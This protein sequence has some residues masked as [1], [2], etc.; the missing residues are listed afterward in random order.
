MPAM[1]RTGDVQL[2]DGGQIHVR[3]IELSDAPGIVELHARMSDRTRYLRFFSSYPRISPAD[4]RRFVTVD[5]HD[6]EALVATADAVLIAVGRYERLGDDGVDAEIAFVVDDVHQGRGIA[7]V[8]LSRLAF[9]AHEA[10]VVRF[11][12][13]VLPG[14]TPMLKVFG[15]AGFVVEQKYSDGIV[16]VAFPIS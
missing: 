12:A 13:D 10:G 16:Q 3:P 5:H 2:P 14:N 8:L 4:L 9:A 11:V 15:S 7:P 6:R 1:T